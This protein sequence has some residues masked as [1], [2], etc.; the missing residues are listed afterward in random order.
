MAKVM[1]FPGYAIVPDSL[2]NEVSLYGQTVGFCFDLKLRYYRGHY[3]S[4]IDEFVLKIDG[5]EIDPSRISFGINGKRL[6][7]PLLSQLASN[8]GRLHILPE[9]RLSR[10]GV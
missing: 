3:L 5:K 9:S 8:F 10:L 7:V 4:C 2:R 6:P 1:K